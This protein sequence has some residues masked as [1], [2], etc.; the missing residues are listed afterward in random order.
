[1]STTLQSKQRKC[2]KPC[3][4]SWCGGTINTGENYQYDYIIGDDG[5][6][7]WRSHLHCLEVANSYW[8]ENGVEEVSEEDFI[9]YVSEYWSAN[10]LPHMAISQVAILFAKRLREERERGTPCVP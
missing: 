10:K 5:P 1:M 6:Y 7:A 8:R 3:R 2:R 9:D 4:C